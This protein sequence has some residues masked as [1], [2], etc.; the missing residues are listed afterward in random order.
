MLD[1]QVDHRRAARRHRED[2]RHHTRILDRQIVNIP[3]PTLYKALSMQMLEESTCACGCCVA[4][5]SILYCCA[6]VVLPDFGC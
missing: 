2:H 6:A 4:I 5:V 3:K 1:A